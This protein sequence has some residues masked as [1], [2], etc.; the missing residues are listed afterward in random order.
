MFCTNCGSKVEDDGVFCTECGIQIKNSP[1][2]SNKELKEDTVSSIEYVYKFQPSPLAIIAVIG[3]IIVLIWFILHKGSSHN[4][5]GFYRRND[6]SFPICTIG[7]GCWKV[8]MA[9][10]GSI[11]AIIGGVFGMFKKEPK[12]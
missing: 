1:V 8:S 6:C 3:G 2:S 5:G 9:F 11:I 4:V 12:Q 10:V 7:D